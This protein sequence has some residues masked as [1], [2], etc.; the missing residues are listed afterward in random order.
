MLNYTIIVHYNVK[1]VSIRPVG[2]VLTHINI[3]LGQ[4]SYK[5]DSLD[6]VSYRDQN[7]FCGPLLPSLP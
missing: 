1:Q 7:I 5:P 6:G 3:G 4:I 2:L